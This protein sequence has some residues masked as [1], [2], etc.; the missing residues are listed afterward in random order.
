MKGAIK[1][2]NGVLF[3]E[4]INKDR[5]DLKL[6]EAEL[7]LNQCK[8]NLKFYKDMINREKEKIKELREYI[9]SAK[10]TKG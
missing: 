8:I 2:D 3:M 10:E 5:K 1:I 6:T 9:L 4:G 7:E